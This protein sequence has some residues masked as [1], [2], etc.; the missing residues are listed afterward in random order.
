MLHLGLFFPRVTS[1]NLVLQ[2]AHAR[3]GAAAA[4]R[5]H[6]GAAAAAAASSSQQQPSAAA[7]IGIGISIFADLSMRL[8]LQEAVAKGK[9]AHLVR[10]DIPAKSGDQGHDASSVQSVD[11]GQHASNAQ[12][13][14]QKGSING[15]EAI[16]LLQYVRG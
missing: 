9:F 15:E 4:A 7:S 3:A 12:Q 6:S 1:S 14:V 11:K 13:H 16:V 2:R 8:Q 5:A 10:T